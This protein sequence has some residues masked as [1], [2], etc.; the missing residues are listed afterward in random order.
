MT[1]RTLA[2]M[3]PKFREYVR[4]QKSGLTNMYDLRNVIALSGGKL[5][6][7]DCLDIME[8]YNEYDLLWGK[9]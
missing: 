7:D 1:T 5:S 6:K 2:E 3:E 8:H 4:I 9:R